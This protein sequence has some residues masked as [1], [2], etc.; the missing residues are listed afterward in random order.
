MPY[1]PSVVV[2]FIAIS[3]NG[4][5]GGTW[6][7]NNNVWL[8][9]IWKERGNTVLQFSQFMYGLGSIIGPIIVSPYVHG[10]N[11]ANQTWTPEERKDDLRVPFAVAGATQALSK[12]HLL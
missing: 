8:S 6:D 9:E 5:G 1:F 3:L 11:T 7:S 4:A 12:F 2:L 10:D